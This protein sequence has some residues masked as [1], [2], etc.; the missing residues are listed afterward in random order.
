L[1][2]LIQPNSSL[3]LLLANDI[4]DAGEIVGFALDTN[5]NATVAF[6]AVPVDSGNQSSARLGETNFYSKAAAENRRRP[7][8][9]TFSRFA[10]DVAHS[11]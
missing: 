9:G 5:R 8:A 6:L 3:Q 11:K 4:N 7:F 2:A 1:N 10:V